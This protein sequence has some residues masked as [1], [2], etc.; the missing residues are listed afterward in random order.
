MKSLKLG[1]DPKLVYHLIL[2]SRRNIIIHFR[3]KFM[4]FYS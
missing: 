2:A 4:N 1:R 3:R